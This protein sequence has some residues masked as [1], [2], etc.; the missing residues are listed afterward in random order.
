MYFSLPWVLPSIAS[1]LI[2]LFTFVFRFPSRKLFIR[3]QW[4]SQCICSMDVRP[5][6]ILM[7]H[8]LFDPSCKEIVA[9]DDPKAKLL[10]SIIVWQFATFTSNLFFANHMNLYKWRCSVPVTYPYSKAIA[11]LLQ[12]SENAGL[13]MQV[14]IYA[15]SKKILN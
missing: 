13:N 12:H 3:V 7:C 2:I 1:L 5:T 6:S 11:L 9:S 8:L 10:V 14:N 15:S 4:M